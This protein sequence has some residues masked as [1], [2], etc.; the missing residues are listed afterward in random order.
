M[1]QNEPEP[2]S[3]EELDTWLRASAESSLEMDVV[4]EAEELALEKGGTTQEWLLKLAKERGF[5][6]QENKI[7]FSE[8]AISRY[9]QER[10][11]QWIQA[12]GSLEKVKEQ[13]PV[14]Y[15]EDMESTRE[16]EDAERLFERP[17]FEPSGIAREDREILD[18]GSV[19]KRSTMTTLTVFTVKSLTSLFSIPLLPLIPITTASLGCLIA[20]PPIGLAYVLIMTLVWAPLSGLLIGM[21]HLWER[22]SLLQPLLALIGIPLALIGGIFISLMPNPDR[23]D[24]II[25]LAICDSFPFSHKVLGLIR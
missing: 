13:M 5:T 6:F 19:L 9:Q 8:E 25:K 3:D 21:S 10:L 18:E 11:Q 1:S 12:W 24:K 14:W 23:E 16:M 15:R 4:A 22:V 20:I 7:K 2:V 17:R